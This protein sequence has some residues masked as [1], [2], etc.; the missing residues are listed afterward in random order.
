MYDALKQHTGDAGQVTQFDTTLTAIKDSCRFSLDD[1]TVELAIA[2][3]NLYTTTMFLECILA[4]N[5][6][7]MYSDQGKDS[8]A[9]AKKWRRV[10]L[11]KLQD[12][13]A[14]LDRWA[15]TFEEWIDKKRTERLSK[16]GSLQIN[17][18]SNSETLVDTRGVYIVNFPH[19]FGFND[20][21]T[22]KTF[23]ARF[24]EKVAQPHAIAETDWDRN[25]KKLFQ[26]KLERARSNYIEGVKK[27]FDDRFQV[28]KVSMSL[29]RR[30]ASETTKFKSRCEAGEIPTGASMYDMLTGKTSNPNLIGF[31][32]ISVLQK[33]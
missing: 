22:Q 3:M 25:E 17:W 26:Q 24:D 12:I 9:T 10:F 33:R 8:E 19:T 20:G 29:Y 31:G 6:Y 2:V 18:T 21:A 30:V 5:F 1:H 4:S 11:S 15:D 23:E 27:A 7:K 14:F 28:L 32:G 16:V 13:A